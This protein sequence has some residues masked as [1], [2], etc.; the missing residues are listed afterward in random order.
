V[1]IAAKGID[2]L[3]PLALPKRHLPVEEERVRPLGANKSGHA[4]LFA[5]IEHRLQSEGV[6]GDDGRHGLILVRSKAFEA[7]LETGF[8]GFH[9][10]HEEE[11]RQGNRGGNDGVNRQETP[12]DSF[13]P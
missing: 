7:L 11:N 12:I 6:M 1:K 4:K 9:V 10:F 2:L 5:R 13:S 8:G 3:G